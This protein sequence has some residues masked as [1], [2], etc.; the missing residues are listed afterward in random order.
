L[1]P[2]YFF[3]A[4]AVVINLLPTGTEPY[5]GALTGN[6]LAIKVVIA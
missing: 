1:R 5:P 3:V 2:H 6:L 4:T